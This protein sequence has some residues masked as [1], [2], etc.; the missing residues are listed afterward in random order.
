MGLTTPQEQSFI[1]NAFGGGAQVVLNTTAFD[2]IIGQLQAVATS[3]QAQETN[4]SPGPVE[5]MS[6]GCYVNGTAEQSANGTGVRAGDGWRDCPQACSTPGM[7]FNSSYTFWNCLT[8]GAASLY[9]EM[10]GTNFDADDLAIVGQ[11][12]GFQTLAEFNGTQIF[13]D[14]LS[15]IKSSCQDYSLGSCSKNITSLTMDSLGS[16]DQV[17][18]LFTG[19]SDYCSGMDS[20]INTDIAGP[21]V[22]T[23]QLKKKKTHFGDDG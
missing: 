10:D 7:M 11:E 16:Q 20:V 2:D 4:Q 13:S 12:L 3:R 1:P 21:G 17:L 22:R 19:L 18:E 9:Q 14:T 23:F 15:C 8:L 5:F 6:T